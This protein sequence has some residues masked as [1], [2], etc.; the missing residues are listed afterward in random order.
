MTA[1]TFSHFFLLL[2][3]PTGLALDTRR[4]KVFW[5]DDGLD[6]IVSANFDGSSQEILVSTDIHSPR[7]IIIQEEEG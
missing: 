5:T 1:L 2:T 4:R 7:S 6:Q 3:D